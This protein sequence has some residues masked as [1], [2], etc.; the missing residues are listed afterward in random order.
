MQKEEVVKKI[1]ETIECLYQNKEK[2]AMQSVAELMPYF[3]NIAEKR[4]TEGSNDILRAI[5]MLKD[6]VD[7]YDQFDMIGMA[8][9]LQNDAYDLIKMYDAE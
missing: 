4:M 5:H 3:H 6:L 2:K 1:G 9:C 8:D 7:N